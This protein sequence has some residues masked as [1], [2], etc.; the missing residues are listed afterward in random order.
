MAHRI[1]G[2]IGQMLT[3]TTGKITTLK[4]KMNF[5]SVP[6]PDIWEFKK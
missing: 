5:W 2:T 4:N 3:P 1:L 6:F